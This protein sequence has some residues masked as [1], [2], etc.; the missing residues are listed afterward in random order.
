MS[1]TYIIYY[2]IRCFTV[3]IILYSSTLRVLSVL[4][5]S[6]PPLV[7]ITSFVSESL[8]ELLTCALAL[9]IKYR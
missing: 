3:S 1:R 6:V 2:L 9:S 7:N 5:D 4:F 8:I